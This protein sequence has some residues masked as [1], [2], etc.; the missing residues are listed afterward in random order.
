[1]FILDQVKKIYV[2]DK[3]GLDTEWKNR[4]SQKKLFGLYSNF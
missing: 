3:P 2:S 4:I 1:M